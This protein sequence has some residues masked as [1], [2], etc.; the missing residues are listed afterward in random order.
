[1]N[2]FGYGGTNA[3]VILEAPED[4][5]AS[6]SQPLSIRI[7]MATNGATNGVNGT[8]VHHQ[9]NGNLPDNKSSD[10]RRL[11][12]FT[13]TA[14]RGMSVMTTNFKQYLQAGAQD[15]CHILDSLAHTLAMRRSRFAYRVA[16]S[17]TNVP[18]L[19]DALE[20]VSKGTIRAQKALQDPKICFAFTGKIDDV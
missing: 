7:P 17:A 9:S 11:F 18:E 15:E 13:H 6:N 8:P 20:E 14:E 16:L 3:H 12:V 10:K 5:L 2:S 19:I 1:M 4:Y